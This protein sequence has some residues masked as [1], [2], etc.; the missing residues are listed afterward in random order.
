M[1]VG[2]RPRKKEA[3]RGP[4][5]NRTFCGLLGHHNTDMTLVSSPGLPVR[6]GGS[7]DETNVTPLHS[8]A[9]SLAHAHAKALF[10]GLGTRLGKDMPTWGES[11]LTEIRKAIECGDL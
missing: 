6:T 7:G 2:P 11:E 10:P 9:R 4:G 3:E 1:L 8:L 5:T